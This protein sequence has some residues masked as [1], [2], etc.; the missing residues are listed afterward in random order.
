MSAAMKGGLSMT[1]VREFTTN[2]VRAYNYARRGADVYGKRVDGLLRLM[3]N[4]RQWL[5]RDKE[6][7]VVYAIYK[8]NIDGLSLLESEK[9]V[10]YECITDGGR[11]SIDLYIFLN[12]LGIR[13]CKQMR[14]NG[15]ILWTITSTD[16]E[17]R[18]IEK[19]TGKISQLES[20]K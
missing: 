6:G 8:V 2:E 12:T 9:V 1:A 11:K 17:A 13:Y 19:I 4:N 10:S 16:Q 18:Q 15:A 14:A 7:I 20:E 5:S 3:P